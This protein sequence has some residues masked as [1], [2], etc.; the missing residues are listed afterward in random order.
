MSAEEMTVSRDT[1]G[2]RPVGFNVIKKVFLVLAIA[3]LF[4]CSYFVSW[5]DLG[6]SW[7]GHPIEEIIDLWGKP[8]QVIT[9][10]NGQRE[11]KYHRRQVDPSCVHYWI[12]NSQDVIT[13]FHYEG[14]CRPIG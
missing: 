3:I 10:G 9:T 1:F 13:G 14:R 8:D 7:V 11:Y 5:D 4:G 2:R 6:N 12:V